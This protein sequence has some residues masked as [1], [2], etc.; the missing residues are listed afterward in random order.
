MNAE[1]V[2]ELM[3]NLSQLSLADVQ[4][5][6]ERAEKTQQAAVTLLEILKN[7]KKFKETEIKLCDKDQLADMKQSQMYQRQ[8]N[9]DSAAAIAEE[10]RV[11]DGDDDDKNWKTLVQR[12][13]QPIQLLFCQLVSI[14]PL[15]LD[16]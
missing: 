10:W 12:I 16:P 6:V 1:A 4:A 5:A 13:H 8:Q 14:F 11:D 3:N 9:L 15:V 2:F 7:A